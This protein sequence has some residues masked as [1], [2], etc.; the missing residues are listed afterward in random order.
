MTSSLMFFFVVIRC[1]TNRLLI[2]V[3]VVAQLRYAVALIQ[4]HQIAVVVRA[5]IVL[6][7]F[8]QCYEYMCASRTMYY[9]AGSFHSF[10][11]FYVVSIVRDSMIHV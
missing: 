8:F 9:Y 1:C 5:G 2:Q 6:V 3:V 10:I 4:L 11:V 7:V